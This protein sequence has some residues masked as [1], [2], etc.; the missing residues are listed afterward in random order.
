MKTIK[1]PIIGQVRIGEEEAKPKAKKKTVFGPDVLGGFLDFSRTKLS[2]E[3]SISEKILK[4]NTGW[5]YTNNDVIA[6]EV[7]KIEYEL[8]T[9][10]LKDGEIVYNEIETHPLLD[11]LDKPNEETTKAD[12][13]Y[14][15][16]S[17]RKLT[18]DAFWLRIRT[19]N[20]TTAL[21]TL[22]PDKI[23]L[24]L[25]APT[26]D[27]PVIIEAYNYKDVIDGKKIDIMY[28]PEDIIHFK[29]PN[30]NNAFRGLGVVE[31]LADTIDL[32]NLTTETTKNYFK[33]G[34]ITNFVLTTENKVTQ[35]QIDRLRAELRSTHGGVNNAY[36]A[37]ILGNGLK[38]EDI[39][40]TNRDLQFIDQ[41][42]WYRDKIMVGFGNTKA[43]IGLIDDVNR[44]SHES[45]TSEWLRNTV[46][47]DMQAIVDTLNEFLVPEFGDNLVLGFVDPV[48]DDR[49]DD[50]D[51]ATKLYAGNIIMRGE[52]RDLLGYEFDD[53]DNVFMQSALNSLTPDDG[54][55]DNQGQED[56][57]NEED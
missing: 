34:A 14:T 4:A 28:R 22:P 2:S 21:R 29:R 13:I 53:D 17:H 8:Y 57:D 20:I 54:S 18:G 56:E 12:S 24:V 3:K 52:A 37:M 49:T 32:D 19:N 10:G 30:P 23:E 33:N 45:A 38:P 16:Q 31:A 55:L 43:S 26:K 35:E 42:T 1:L 44:A 11:L 25:K 9:V 5:V 7:A 27:D 50:V 47:P 51:E 48:P 39:S 15:I 40:Y 41:L 6:R 36:K 46:K